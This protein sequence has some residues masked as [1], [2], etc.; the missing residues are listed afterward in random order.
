MASTAGKAISLKEH[1]QVLKETN[2]ILNPKCEIIR[3]NLG[4]IYRVKNT[5]ISLCAPFQT[6]TKTMAIDVRS[7]TVFFRISSTSV[8]ES[9]FPRLAFITLKKAPSQVY[10]VL[11]NGNTS[12]SFHK[13]GNISRVNSQIWGDQSPFS[14]KIGDTIFPCWGGSSTYDLYNESEELIQCGLEKDTR[15]L[16]KQK[17]L[18]S[19]AISS[20]M[21]KEIYS[22]QSSVERRS[23]RSR[24]LGKPTT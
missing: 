19:P 10:E 24:A 22:K 9:I 18:S 14:L 20:P 21:A 16:Y 8:V 1:V 11:G 17:S 5:T 15:V 7:G 2:L 23:S 6:K 4:T 13:N 12:L 3:T